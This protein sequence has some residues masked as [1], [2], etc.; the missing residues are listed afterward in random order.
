MP[1]TGKTG[2]PHFRDYPLNRTCRGHAKI[3]AN[4]PTATS[5]GACA[6]YVTAYGGSHVARLSVNHLAA[7][8][9]NRIAPPGRHRPISYPQGVR[10]I[11]PESDPAW[12]GKARIV[13]GWRWAKAAAPG[14]SSR[15]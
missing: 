13:G 1:S 4:D 6:A 8:C 9:R 12:I 15:H 7:I 3:D 10:S 2:Q 5:R 14:F 11:L